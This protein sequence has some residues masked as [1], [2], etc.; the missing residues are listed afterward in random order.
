[1]TAEHQAVETRPRQD[2]FQHFA[3]RKGCFR[4]WMPVSTAKEVWQVV[5]GVR[6]GRAAPV[7]VAVEIPAASQEYLG[8]LGGPGLP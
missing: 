8:S 2:Q 7:A 3:L 4:V 6:L 1:M 5:R